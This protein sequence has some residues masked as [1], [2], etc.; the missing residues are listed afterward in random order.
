LDTWD[1]ESELEEIRKL[2]NPISNRVKEEILIFDLRKIDP[3]RDFD[4]PEL[5]A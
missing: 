1:P 5:K 4:N 2:K 3:L